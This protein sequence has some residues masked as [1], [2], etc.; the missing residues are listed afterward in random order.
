MTV[1]HVYYRA[2]TAVYA[3]VYNYNYIDY[4]LHFVSLVY[5]LLFIIFE[6]VNV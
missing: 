4:I 3:M 1:N 2:T 5:T 6:K